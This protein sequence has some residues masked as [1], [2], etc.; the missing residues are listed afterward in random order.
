VKLVGKRLLVEDAQHGI[1]A[2]DAWHHRHAKVDLAALLRAL[3]RPSCGTRRSAMSSSD[4]TLM[5]EMTCSASSMPGIVLA[6]VSTPSMRYL[7]VRPVL[8]DSGDVA[9]PVF[10]AS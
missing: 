1:L 8:A 9:R 5:R 10:S 3:K 2:E 4:I 6:G 7:I